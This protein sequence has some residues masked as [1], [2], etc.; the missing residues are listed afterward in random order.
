MKVI[1]SEKH[2]AIFVH[3]Q[4]TGGISM[5]S[6]LKEAC[7]DSRRLL[8]R[9][10][11]VSEGIREL[12][13]DNWNSYYSF[14]FVRNPWDRL[15]SWY[16]MIQE[17]KNMLPFWKQWQKEPF[18]SPFHNQV[19]RE[20]H[21]FESFLYNCTDVVYSNKCHKSYAFNQV[22]YISD[23]EGNIAVNF[24]GKFENLSNDHSSIFDHLK[25]NFNPLPSKNSSRHKHYS[26][27][28]TSETRDLVAKRFH[29]DIETFNYQFDK[30]V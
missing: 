11:H 10:S 19:I 24:V 26:Q 18:K 1:I 15:V 20:S 12:G 4:K 30:K 3:I 17:K 27:Y 21:D 14:A 7:V 5:Q 25:L 8:G 16:S 28:Y 22:D 6:A 29:K 9:H 13:R 2:K 23:S